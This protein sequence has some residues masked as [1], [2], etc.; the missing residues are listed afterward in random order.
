MHA[1]E[2][3]VVEAKR[4]ELF[5]GHRSEQNLRLYR[6]LGY[7]DCREVTVAPHLRLI[8]LEKYRATVQ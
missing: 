7:T 3:D 5:T 4:Y 1:I 8:Y 2:T 6:W